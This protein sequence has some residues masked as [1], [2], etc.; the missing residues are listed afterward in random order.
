MSCLV[1]TACLFANDV[2]ELDSEYFK[3]LQE[4]VTTHKRLSFWFKVRERSW[5]GLI[6]GEKVI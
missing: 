1:K 6:D 2:V 5:S 3:I 4:E